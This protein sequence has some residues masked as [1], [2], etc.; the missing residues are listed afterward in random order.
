MKKFFN[1]S[2][3]ENIIEEI[4]PLKNLIPY[5]IITSTVLWVF[6]VSVFVIIATIVASIRESVLI[7]AISSK[8]I[9]FSM[10]Q[11][12]ILFSV[13]LFGFV[14][15]GINKYNNQY[16]WITNKRVICKHGLFGYTLT[17]IPFERISDVMLSR[18]FWE[19]LCGFGSI[20]IQT[21]GAIEEPEG[22]LLA[23]PNPESLQEKIFKLISQKR[24]KEK[25]TI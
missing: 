2:E 10:I 5:F 7:S 11:Y 8:L 17:S 18:T 16:Y 6:M 19:R 9:L 23:V 22:Q 21:I 12:I 24:K 25:L 15:L 13:I 14:L 20:Y 3:K 1:L 4:K